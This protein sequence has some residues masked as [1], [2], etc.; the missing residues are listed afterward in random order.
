MDISREFSYTWVAWRPHHIFAYRIPTY[1]INLYFLNLIMLY[2]RLESYKP[3][4][5]LDCVF[6]D[7]KITCM[8]NKNS[9]R[10]NYVIETSNY[11]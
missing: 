3:G 2:Y 5:K 4:S 6:F 9:V 8:L 11:V 10:V 7:H 1:F